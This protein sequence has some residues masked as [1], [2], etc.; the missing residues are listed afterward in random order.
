MAKRVPEGEKPYR[1]LDQSLIRSVMVG[2]GGGAAVAEIPVPIPADR[3]TKTQVELP[4]QTPQLR[5]ARPAA[6]VAPEVRVEQPVAQ[7]LRQE[8]RQ[9]VQTL[10]PERLDREKRVLVT[11]GEEND[12]QRLVTRLAAELGTPLKLSHVLRS[13][14]TLVRNC[15]DEL[16][17]H[18]RRTKLTRPGNGNA[19]E[20]AQFEFSLAQLL[21]SALRDAKPLR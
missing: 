2:G 9:A 15:E 21:T 6:Q 19:P 1:P 10:G 18:A 5:I 14:I 16:V 12:L 4:P 13:C 7:I 11:I 3:E 20:L 8:P 17:S